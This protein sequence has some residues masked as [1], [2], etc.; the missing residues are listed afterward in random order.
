MTII[1]NYLT[2]NNCYIVGTPLKP[3][4]I[5][6]HSTACP[7]AMAKNFLNSWN[8]PKPNN[9][10]VCVHGFLDN[11]GFYQT[12]PWT[13]KGWHAGGSANSKLIG[14]EICEPKNYADKVYFENVKH[15][16]IELCVFLCQKFNLSADS[17]TT[18]CEGYQKYGS[19]YASNHGDIHHWW[20]VY[21]NYTISDFRND[22]RKELKRLKEIEADEKMLQ[23]YIDKYGEDIVRAGLTKI[24]ET[25]KNKNHP[26]PWAEAELR[27]AMEAGITDGSRPQDVATRQEVA[28][29][30]KRGAK[31]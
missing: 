30:V 13:I 18:H 8:V 3:Q 28:I 10:Q 29:M 21:H 16:A 6:L 22:V 17:I 20:K 31:K 7:S 15:K 9:V 12:L 2:K 19:S 27:E 11:T 5:M 4:G 14:F 1:E 25:E 23:E 26:S 24:F